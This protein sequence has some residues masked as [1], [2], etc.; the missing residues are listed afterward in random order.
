MNLP[1]HLKEL[2]H[3]KAAT[4]REVQE[5]TGVSN[6]YLN[7]LE[8]GRAKSPSPSVLRTLADYYG[9]SYLYLMMLAGYL[10][11]SEPQQANHPQRDAIQERLRNIEVELAAIKKLL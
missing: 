4:L 6:A 11:S 1:Q 8:N 5:A 2:R 7:Q 10:E 3:L 9:V